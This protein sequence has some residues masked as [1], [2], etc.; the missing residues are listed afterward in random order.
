V[1]E[2]CNVVGL[3]LPLASYIAP[4]SVAFVGRSLGLHPEAT[5]FRPKSLLVTL[6]RSF[7][8]K[9]RPSLWCS[10]GQVT[11]FDVLQTN[12]SRILGHYLV[13]GDGTPGQSD[14]HAGE[15][16]SLPE[17]LAE[18]ICVP[19]CSCT[20]RAARGSFCHIAVRPRGGE[21]GRI[22]AEGALGRARRSRSLR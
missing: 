19:C 3:R 14:S 22:M 6:G 20:S 9:P 16:S 10:M 11:L 5:S 15:I 17:P 8:S 2:Q 12:D 4:T 7:S 21:G 1:P 18:Q 13:S